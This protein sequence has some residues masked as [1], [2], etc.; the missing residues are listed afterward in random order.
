MELPTTEEIKEYVADFRDFLKEGTIP[1]CKALIRN[2]VEGIEVNG[3]EAVL[4]Y[5]IPMPNDGVTTESA[6]VFDF[7]KSGP[8]C[9][10]SNQLVGP[11]SASLLVWCAA[12]IRGYSHRGWLPPSGGPTSTA[13]IGV[14]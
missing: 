12:Q 4:T 2:F 5:T 9:R 13:V 7:V 10:D 14:D 6:S 8:T 11:S 3:D 1:E